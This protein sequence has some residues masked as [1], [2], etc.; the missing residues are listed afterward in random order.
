MTGEVHTNTIENFWSVL[1]RGLFGIYHQVSDKHFERYLNEF[2]TRFNS[3]EL[4]QDERF[5]LF[6]KDSQGAL[7]YKNLIRK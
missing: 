3:R 5:E 1:K 2:A 7:T 4:K 6:L